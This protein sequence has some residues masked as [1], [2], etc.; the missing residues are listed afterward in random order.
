M[1]S[2][3]L[4]LASA[5]PRRRELLDSMGVSFEVVV[6]G[7]DEKPWPNEKPSSY[8]LRNAAEKAR[9]VWQRRKGEVLILAADTIVVMDDHILEKPND[10][11]HAAAMAARTFPLT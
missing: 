1:K 9:E 11:G 6:S 2:T 7:V 3:S 4:I 10:G 5:S 8:A